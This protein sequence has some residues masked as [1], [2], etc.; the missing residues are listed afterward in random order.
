MFKEGFRH[1]FVSIKPNGILG[2][3]YPKSLIKS[4]VDRL[5]ERWILFRISIFDKHSS[6]L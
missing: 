5:Q 6:R 2:H 4:L 1:K 3:A